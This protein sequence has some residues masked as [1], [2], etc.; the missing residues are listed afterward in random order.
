MCFQIIDC[1]TKNYKYNI[2]YN[3]FTNMNLIMKI[4]LGVIGLGVI[5]A[6]IVMLFDTVKQLSDEENLISSSPSA[7]TKAV[8]NQ[9]VSCAS[10]N[11]SSSCTDG[12]SKCTWKPVV[13]STCEGEGSEGMS[14]SS[15]KNANECSKDGCWAEY[16]GNWGRNRRFFA[17]KGLQTGT[18]YKCNEFETDEGKCSNREGCKPKYTSA[19]CADA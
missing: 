1:V 2:L 17:C 11:T 19:V 13:F 16:K 12:S 10:R 4:G 5:I 14:C 9:P 6:L 7:D 8:V 18:A 15:F 3:K